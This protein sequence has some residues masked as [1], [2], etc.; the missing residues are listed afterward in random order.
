[1]KNNDI[2]NLTSE[3]KSTRIIERMLMD[4]GL[5]L[6]PIKELT[7]QQTIDFMNIC[8]YALS[9]NRR[10]VSNVLMATMIVIPD[11][12]LVKRFKR[13]LF[14]KYSVSKKFSNV[15]KRY[16]IQRIINGKKKIIENKAISSE[17]IYYYENNKEKEKIKSSYIKSGID[18]RNFTHMIYISNG[19]TS[20]VENWLSKKTK[21]VKV[22]EHFR[23]V[24]DISKEKIEAINKIVRD[25]ENK[26]SI[27][28]ITNKK[29]LSVNISDDEKVL[30]V[31]SRFKDTNNPIFKIIDDEK[32]P[33]EKK[34]ML[35]YCFAMG[36]FYNKNSCIRSFFINISSRIM[37]RQKSQILRELIR[38]YKTSKRYEDL[39]KY[40]FQDCLIGGWGEFK[41]DF[42]FARLVKELLIKY[43]SYEPIK[44]LFREQG[45]NLYDI[46]K[47]LE[48]DDNWKKKFTRIVSGINDNHLRKSLNKIYR[49]SQFKIQL[50]EQDLY[51]VRKNSGRLYL[52]GKKGASK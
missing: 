15:Q 10:Y 9:F 35:I 34:M 36:D 42:I 24:A 41:K 2:K 12:R 45:I 17:I 21:N 44:V 26:Q 32:F 38:R 5:V 1:M 43:G 37:E 19:D 47:Q 25:M 7:Q 39:H 27:K 3:S 14:Q 8:S 46:A 20:K 40:Y 6:N 13:N 29:E 30:A 22:L 48:E 49:D 31:I 18:L 16:L 33:I 28:G 11:Y 50:I 4:N 23:K 51:C 52:A